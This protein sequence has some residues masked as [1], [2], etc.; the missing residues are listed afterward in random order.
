M[1]QTVCARCYAKLTARERMAGKLLCSACDQ[2]WRQ[3]HAATV[4]KKSFS[5]RQE[6]KW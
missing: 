4:L 1:A 3:L 2:A 6:S 5:G